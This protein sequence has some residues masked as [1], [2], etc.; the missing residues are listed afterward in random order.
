MKTLEYSVKAMDVIEAMVEI[1]NPN[2]VTDAGV[3][4]LCA[5][6]AAIGAYY[7]V[8]INTGDLKDEEFKKKVLE[9]GEKLKEEAIQR[10]LKIMKMVEEKI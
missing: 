10:E 8:R 2:S 5:R 1:G 6:S 3:G 9:K 7:N 4:A